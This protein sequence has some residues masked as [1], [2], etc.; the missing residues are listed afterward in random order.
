VLDLGLPGM[1]GYEVARRL[2]ASRGKDVG[3]IALSGYGQPE[4]RRRALAAG[5]DTHV[6]KP[7]DPAH[8]SAVIAALAVPRRV[9]RPGT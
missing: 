8:L 5:F 7:V 6:V 2:R 9:S 1:D 3:L 4:D